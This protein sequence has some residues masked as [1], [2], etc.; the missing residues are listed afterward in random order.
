M[1]NLVP[2]IINLKEV[3]NFVPIIINLKEVINFVPIIINL[4]D[5][6]SPQSNINL[7][8][9]KNLNKFKGSENLVPMVTQIYGND[10]VS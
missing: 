6:F 8:V 10:K 2:I 7:K 4:S 1:I 5:Q 3:I 9:L